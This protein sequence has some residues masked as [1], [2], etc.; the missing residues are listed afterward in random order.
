M[1]TNYNK[2]RGPSYI[3]VN[4]HSLDSILAS[5]DTSKNSTKYD[6]I[7]NHFIVIQKI[8]KNQAPLIGL[9]LDIKILL[10]A[11][12]SLSLL[13]GSYFKCIMYMYAFTTNRKNPGWL[14]RPINVLTVTSAIIHH[15]THVVAGIWYILV[16]MM[17]T[18]LIDTF[19]FQSCHVMMVVASYGV[20]YLSVGSL[21][22]AI[23]RVMYIRQEYFVK[24]VIG[25]KALLSIV[26]F[27]SNV[28]TG[29]ITTLYLIE[30]HGDRPG[31]NM[32]T[33]LSA[34]QTQIMI[35]YRMSAEDQLLG[36]KYQESMAIFLCIGTQT[37]E[38]GIYIWFFYYRYKNDNGKIAQL[39]SQKAIGNRNLKNAV[40]FLGQFYGFV[41][42]YSFLISFLVLLQH[43][44]EH[45]Q[46]F[47]ALFSMVKFFD[48]GVLSALEVLTS[49]G[50][51]GYM[52][53]GN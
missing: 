37:I 40:T 35:E 47:R 46:H 20:A 18:P 25:E 44:D 7:D 51:R 42:E 2:Q 14:H 6:W 11:I 49:P 17:R 26:L 31:I 45:T 27:L 33:G 12:M 50:I 28:L 41:I 48:F 34:T 53:Y 1:M 19:G 9:S 21:G 43:A 39:L 38:F 16:L 8:S 29:L 24:Y 52:K 32:C 22:I 13:I 3:P 36:T 5:L 23:Y 15:G 4:L 10:T 30:N